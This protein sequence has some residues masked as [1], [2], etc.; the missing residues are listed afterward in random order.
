MSYRAR[1][2]E[3]KVSPKMLP[4]IVAV[5]LGLWLGF[6]AIGLTLWG[7]WQLL[8]S[9]HEPVTAALSQPLAP[10]PAQQPPATRQPGAA[11]QSPEQNRMFEQYQQ[12]LQTRQIEDAQNRAEENPRNLSNPKCQ[13]WLQQNRTA[14]T[15]KSRAN[16]L[17]FCH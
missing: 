14:P 3:L 6:V 2:R 16:V 11:Q 4:L 10:P 8:P 7:A 15:E 17:E 1:R 12:A 13:F 5:A 9:L